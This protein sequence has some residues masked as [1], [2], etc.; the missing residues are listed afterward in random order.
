[1]KKIILIIGVVFW[2]S[3]FLSSQ[4]KQ[5]EGWQYTVGAGTI[6]SPNY[7]G[8]DEGQLSLFPNIQI[9]YGDQFSASFF[10]G[11]RYRVYQN[12]DWTI[13]P[14]ARYHFGREEDG[15]NP[16]AL[17]DD[18]DDLLGL[19]DVDGSL[20]VGVFID[21]D[22]K[23]FRTSFE[24]RQGLGGHEG[25]V[26]ELELSYQGNA[27]WQNQRFIYSIGLSLTYTDGEYNDRFFGVNAQQSSASGLAVYDADQATL[28]YGIGGTLIIP[29]SAKISTVIFASYTRLGETIEDSSLVSERGDPNQEVFGVFVNYKF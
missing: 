10:D 26:S 18:T 14:I 9:A 19:G 1:M 2:S 15:S 8:D 27:V 29:H 16:F 4:P 5:A 11:I 23:P 21:Y 7:K 17:G 28:S 3:C 24:I 22:W 12:N 20:E 25:L 13:G 6:Y